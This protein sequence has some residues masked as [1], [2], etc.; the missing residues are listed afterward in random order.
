MA[1]LPPAVEPGPLGL[2]WWLPRIGGKN[3]ESLAR[4][5]R[6]REAASAAFRAALN[7]TQGYLDKLRQDPTRD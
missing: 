4:P 3:E 2:D 1:V 5:A 7:E 6:R